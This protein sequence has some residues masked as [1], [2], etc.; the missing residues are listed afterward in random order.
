LKKAKQMT[1]SRHIFLF[2]LFL[3]LFYHDTFSS[4]RIYT[5]TCTSK[6]Q[7]ITVPDGYNYMYVD[8]TG[9]AGGGGGTGGIP[10]YGAR[11]QSYF[12]VTPGTILHI[13][14]GC[15]GSDCGTTVGYIPGGY[16]GGGSS[17]GSSTFF[18][19]GGGGGTDIR[20][21][22]LQLQ[23]RIIVAGGGGGYYCYDNCGGPR[24]GGDG[25][26]FGNAGAPLPV[27][28]G[29]CPKNEFPGGRGGNWTTGGSAGASVSAPIA[30]AGL[31]GKGGNGGQITSGGGGGGYYG[32]INI[33]F[34]CIVWT[35]FIC[36]HLNRW[37]R[38]R[39]RCGW[40][41]FQYLLWP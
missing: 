4:S 18:S 28:S 10:G 37:R 7:N 13:N 40:R 27:V 24:K 1:L 23:N 35:L 38:T 21:G 31:L 34:H 12:A 16:N 26:K 25:G 5:F 9:A 2:L 36:F 14:V 33:L 19:T 17:Y 15:R 11:V 22:G 3:F 41:W 20:I 32:G 29:G 39:W 6:M 8:M 30:T